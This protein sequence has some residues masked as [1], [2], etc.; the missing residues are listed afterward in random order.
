[1]ENIL[2]D[3]VIINVPIYNKFVECVTKTGNYF[4]DVAVWVVTGP[5]RDYFYKTLIPTDGDQTKS[6]FINNKV[7]VLSQTNEGDLESKS[8]TDLYLPE[9]IAYDYDMAFSM[10]GSS[11]QMTYDKDNG[12]LQNYGIGAGKP[13]SFPRDD[14][15]ITSLANKMKG[16]QILLYNAAGVSV[17]RCDDLFVPV[18]PNR[19]QI[20]E[21]DAQIDPAERTILY[22]NGTIIKKELPTEDIIRLT[23]I[24]TASGGQC[25]IG[26]VLSKISEPNGEEYIKKGQHTNEGAV[27]NIN[28]LLNKLT[29]IDPAL[30]TTV[31]IVNREKDEDWGGAWLKEIIKNPPPFLNDTKL[32][33]MSSGQ[34]VKYDNDKKNKYVGRSSSTIEKCINPPTGGKRTRRRGLHRTRGQNINKNKNRSK[35]KGKNKHHYKTRGKRRY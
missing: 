4:A 10:G 19:P 12:E 22:G 26:A 1:M 9:M 31:T 2:F 35:N 34:L 6:Y 5:G 23:D 15:V 28:I 13:F 30:T 17:A 27:K 24:I 3:T 33:E 20:F 29:E 14:A 32:G 16:K 25:K 11:T 7:L 8:F 18:Y 21:N